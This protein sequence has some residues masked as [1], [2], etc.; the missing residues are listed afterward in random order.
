MRLSTL[1]KITLVFAAALMPGRVTAGEILY[2]RYP[3][4]SPEG[5]TIAFTYRGD[6]W[7]VPAS[8]G[9]AVRLT[10]HEAED[11]QP[12][13]SPDGKWLMF[14]SRRFDNYDV[15]IMPAGGG[16]ARQLTVNTADDY[17]TGWFPHSDSVVFY[18]ERD[19]RSDIF[20]VAVG[21]GTAIKLTGDYFER[22]YD[23]KI[24]PDGRYMIFNNGSGISRWW[25]RDLRTAENSDIFLQDRS[26]KQFSS[27]R[28]TNHPTHEIWPVLN[29]ARSEVYYVANYDD[30]WAQIYKIPMNGGEP[31][32]LTSFKD[33][34]VQWLNAT[35]DGSKLVFEQGFKVWML[36]PA[37]GKSSEV[38]I[39][40]DT[41]ER[42]NIA[43]RKLLDGPIQWYDVSPDNKKIAVVMQGEVFVIPAEDAVE[44]R[45]ISATPAREHHVVWGADSKT[46][47]YCSDRD[48]D[49]AIYSAD[50]TTGSEK[51][52]TKSSEAEM[53]PLP[54]PDGKYLAFF[55]GLDKI[56]RYE[57]A[58][59]QE[60]V[61][62]KGGFHDYAIEEVTEFDWSSDSKWL[63]YSMIGPTYESDIWLA[64]LDGQQKN[65]S[66]FA[67]YNYRPKFSADGKMVYFTGTLYDRTETFK[68]DLAEKPFEFFESSLD[69]L[70][71]GKAEKDTVK[72]KG[73][74]EKKKSEL[75]I[76][77][78]AIEKRRK[79]AFR[80]SGDNHWPVLTPDEKRFFFVASLLGKSEIWSVVAEDES[81]L[82]QLTS[83]GK[84]KSQLEISADGKKLY[85]L[86]DGKL[87]SL[88]VSDGKSESI[89]FKAATD[90]DALANYRQKFF[91]GW[92]MLKNYFYD[93]TFRG[94]DWQ[95]T[96][97][98]YEPVLPSIRTD[99]EFRNLMTELMGELRG[100]HMDYVLVESKPAETIVSAGIG[101][102]FD[103]DAI[104]KGEGFRAQYVLPLSPAALAGVKTGQYVIAINKTKLSRESDFDELLAG[105]V[106]KRTLLSVAE[107]P[108]GAA[109]E[110][111]VKP[112]AQS[113][114]D[115][116]RYQDWVEQ[117][118]RM[119]DSLSNGR[120]AYL[121]IRAMNQPSLDLFKEQLVSIA[122]AK[123]AMIVDVRE[124]GGGS[125]AVHIL[126]MLDRIPWLMRSFRNFATV[127]ENKYRSKAFERPL[128]CL[129]NGYSGSN[130]EIFAE[131]FR[132]HQLGPIIG[133]PTGGAVIG[134]AEY[135]LIDGSRIR[136]PSWGAYTLDKEDI[137]LKP[138]Q[139][140]VFV[141][142][143]PDDVQ[144]GRDAQLRQAVIELMK[145]LK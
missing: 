22:E 94:I 38:R 138:R 16:E 40:T 39:S 68:I 62:I 31:A 46:L 106:G 128:A 55:R 124:N 74:K 9:E 32:A 75:T 52:L 11:I 137:D 103:F 24:S 58:T 15:F 12:H 107:S 8:G 76:D 108:S 17:G 64:S 20:K 133:T 140:D 111:E 84:A 88:T 96:R 134:T 85:F 44:A 50:A 3:A 127:S 66:R 89:A 21:G 60:T 51:R 87:K 121:H 23:G 83:S 102:D 130:A 30:S 26:N 47:F 82:K 109:R 123:E 53:K 34:G 112:V 5:R 126:G 63:V 125:T 113:A 2:A 77:F 45:R 14:S 92:R 49:Y 142:N 139:P 122:E 70:F 110:L 114:I 56:V 118:R 91:E 42:Q 18:S 143:L 41:D 120:I 131:G 90:F 69:S 132:I 116:L 145:K 10:V 79:R 19:S 33:D 72:A 105:Q 97:D 115:A 6:I 101:I 28:L 78:N 119:V 98:K 100:S 71:M 37:S 27:I 135:Y 61:W 57:I 93:P 99:E 104:D 73:D 144:M 141:E 95:A 35:P 65:I 25:R 1:L 29:Q 136:R 43:M 86:D 48:G 36:D 67:G 13:Y 117:R 80:L 7:S 4:L 59:G 54:S 129:I 81:E